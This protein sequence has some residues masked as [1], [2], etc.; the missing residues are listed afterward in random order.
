MYDSK[1]RCTHWA[2]CNLDAACNSQMHASRCMLELK[3]V[4][5]DQGQNG[6]ISSLENNHFICRLAYLAD[7]QCSNN[8][9]KLIWNCKYKEEEG[10]SSILLT[11]SAHSWKNLT[12]GSENIKQEILLCSRWSHCGWWWSECWYNIGICSTPYWRTSWEICAVLSR[13]HQNNCIW[14]KIFLLLQSRMLQYASTI[15]TIL[16]DSGTKYVFE[17]NKICDFWLKVSDIYPNVGNEALIKFLLFPSTYLCECGFSTL[18]HVKT[19]NRNRVN[20]T[21]EQQF[22]TGGAR[23][24]FL[25]CE[26]LW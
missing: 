16:N 19:K 14:W 13:I 4:P 9:R 10:Q 22:S 20:F 25:G 11:P 23:R 2:L 12:V 15:I 21:L 6:I 8:S 7:M 18:L 24:D 17:T 1:L 26:L 5:C 3:S